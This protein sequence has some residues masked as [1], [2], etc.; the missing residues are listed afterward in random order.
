MEMDDLTDTIQVLRK[1]IEER[2]WSKFHNSKDLAI[3]INVESGELLE[4]FLWKS[5]EEVPEAKIKE[6][7]ADILAFALLLADKHNFSISDIL[8]EKMKT[9][10]LKYPIDKSRGSSKK[11][12]EL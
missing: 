6:E 5:P 11:Y 8:L 10:A 2:D 12:N 1:F 3:A 7:L 4:L 9:N